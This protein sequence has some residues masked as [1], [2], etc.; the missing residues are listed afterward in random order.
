MVNDEKEKVKSILFLLDSF[1]ISDEAYHEL[2]VHNKDMVKSYLIKQCRENIN[3]TFSILKT[4][5]LH[6]GAQLHLS[7][8]LDRLLDTITNIDGSTEIQ[9]VQLK[10]AAD[11]AKVSRISSFLVL[12]LAVLN[13]GEEVM[14]SANQHTLAIV[15]SNEKYFTLKECFGTIFNQN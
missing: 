13:D 9:T 5:G 11:G 2:T 10:F 3:N 14:S 12:S 7:E 15:S 6:Q 1:C 4:P 8:T